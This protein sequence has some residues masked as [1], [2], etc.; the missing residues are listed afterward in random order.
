MDTIAY[1]EFIGKHWGDAVT[2]QNLRDKQT[3]G[4][5]RVINEGDM[6]TMDWQET[7]LNVNLDGQG[8][9]LSFNFS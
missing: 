4:T 6:V 5:L 3:F 8:N 9:I 7:R 2:E 1:N